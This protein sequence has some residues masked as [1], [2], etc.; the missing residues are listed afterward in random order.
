MMAKMPGIWRGKSKPSEAELAADRLRTEE[1]LAAIFGMRF[2]STTTDDGSDDVAA[3]LDLAVARIEPELEAEPGPDLGPELEPEWEPEPELGPDAGVEPEEDPGDDPDAALVDD[4]LPLASAGTG[5]DLVAVMV[6]SEEEPVAIAPLLLAS[7]PAPAMPDTRSAA[8]PAPT[9]VAKPDRAATPAAAAKSV[10]VGKPAA[11]LAAKPTAKTAATPAAAAKTA[12]V[13]KPAAKAKV[14]KTAATPA[15]AAKS[16]RVGKPA[17][18]AT[19]ASRSAAKSSAVASCPWCA[20][21]LEPEPTSSRRCVQCRQRIIVKRI[22]GRA[23]FLAEAVLSVFEAERRR[24]AN[25]TRL[26]REAHRWLRLAAVAG[27]PSERVEARALAAQARPSEE[28]VVASRA[29]YLATVERAY[30]DA[31]RGRRWDEASR[32]RRDHAIVI[33]RAAGSPLPPSEAVLTLYHEAIAAQLR[34]I[35]EMVRDAELAAASCCDACRADDHRVA[36]ISAE[37][38][39]PSLPHPACPKGL[40]SCRWALP[41][42]HQATVQRYARRRSAAEARGQRDE[43]QQRA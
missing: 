28:A 2:E 11:K 17:A 9:T 15:A 21:L 5:R 22:D 16:A 33:H 27:A 19:V 29:L 6:E 7:G 3:P 41:T 12:R 40:C 42:R 30:Q 18:K 4:D 14:A 1:R 43:G 31:R 23:V 37:L 26:A 32:V 36:R 38:R 24:T 35:A 34:G 39:A 10:R 13:E 20:V 8:N 25:A